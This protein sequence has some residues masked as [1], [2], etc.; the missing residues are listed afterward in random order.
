MVSD[1]NRFLDS[2]CLDSI[3]SYLELQFY[4]VVDVRR[5]LAKLQDDAAVDACEL[6]SL[7]TDELAGSLHLIILQGKE[8]PVVLQVEDVYEQTVVLASGHSPGMGLHFASTGTV[9]GLAVLAH[10]LADGLQSADGF[11]G[12][13]AIGL[14]TD[15]QQ[16]VGITVL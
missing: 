4:H 3:G 16:Q 1:L 9:D 8:Q 12:Q 14:G 2:L 10:P 6:H 11:C 13:F 15:V 7:A 5:L